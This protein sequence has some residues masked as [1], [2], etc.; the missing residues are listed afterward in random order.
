MPE[1]ALQLRFRHLLHWESTHVRKS[2]WLKRFRRKSLGHGAGSAYFLGSNQ[3][4]I[5][6]HISITPT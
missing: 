5:R 3:A 4:S 1:A 2:R 6:D